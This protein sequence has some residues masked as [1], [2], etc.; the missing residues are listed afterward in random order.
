MLDIYLKFRRCDGFDQIQE[1]RTVDQF[2]LKEFLQLF[3]RK[4][5]NHIIDKAV[6]TVSTPSALISY[7]EWRQAKQFIDLADDFNATV[8]EIL[9]NLEDS[10]K[11][12]N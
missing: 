4:N 7:R 8:S 2:M 10:N 12:T 5:I 1:L 9:D 11:V 3:N 6:D